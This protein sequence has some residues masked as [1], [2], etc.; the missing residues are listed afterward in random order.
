MSDA[1]QCYATTRSGERCIRDAVFRR[2]GQWLCT[3]H[4]QQRKR[5]IALIEARYGAS[6][7]GM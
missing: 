6:R 1:H 3:Q 4:A 5:K 2:D 7:K